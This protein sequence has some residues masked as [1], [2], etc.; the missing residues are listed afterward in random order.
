MASV[1][2]VLSRLAGEDKLSTQ[3]AQSNAWANRILSHRDLPPSL[4]ITP[5][6]PSARPLKA[7]EVVNERVCETRHVQPRG[8]L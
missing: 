6:T 1:A 8:D 4:E 2:A 5:K 7:M 3:T